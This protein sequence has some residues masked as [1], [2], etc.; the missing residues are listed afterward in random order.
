M[1]NS[2]LN[3]DK[4]IIIYLNLQKFDHF[5]KLNLF[6]SLFYINFDEFLKQEWILC[7]HYKKSYD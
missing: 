1:T 2:V 6:F 4:G 5:N 7:K 3:Y